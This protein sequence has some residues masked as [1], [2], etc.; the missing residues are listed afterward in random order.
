METGDFN[1]DEINE[2]AIWHKDAGNGYAI[3][4]YQWSENA[5][6]FTLLSNCPAYYEKIAS[7]YE[8]QLKNDASNRS[9]LYYY[10]D[11]CIKAGDAK[12]ALEQSGRGTNAIL[13]YG[14]PPEQYFYR[15][16]GDAYYLQDSF[17]NAI[18][19]YQKALEITTA[20][21]EQLQARYHMAVC[22]YELKQTQ[23]AQKQITQALNQGSD[24][25]EFS[26]AMETYAVWQND[27]QKEVDDNE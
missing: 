21:P 25:A 14:Y 13:G 24:W 17:A 12:T 11:A 8:E 22:H 27:S 6:A 9:L 23:E 19:A 1:E 26:K 3:Q 16:K 10:A 20:E 15:I 7:Y 2:L 4:V 5:S 18:G